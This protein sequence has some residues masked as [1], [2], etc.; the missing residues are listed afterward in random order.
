MFIAQLT[1]I[2][3]VAIKQNFV[4]AVL[5]LPLPPLTVSFRQ[6]CMETF[7]PNSSTLSLQQGTVCLHVFI[8]DIH[9]FSFHRS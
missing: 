7:H 1:L 6:F 8:Q 9:G 2:G 5:L 4:A 3:M